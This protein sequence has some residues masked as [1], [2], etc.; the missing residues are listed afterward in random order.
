MDFLA[1]SSLPTS[2]SSMPY[3]H[4]IVKFP[5]LTW[6]LTLNSLPSIPYTHGL[7]TS[8]PS[9]GSLP[10]ALTAAS[11][12]VPAL[13]LRTL[14]CPH[15]VVKSDCGEAGKAST[16]VTESAASLWNEPSITRI[17]NVKGKIQRQ[18]RIRGSQKPWHT[19]VGAGTTSKSAHTHRSRTTMSAHAQPCRQRTTKSTH[20]ECKIFR[21]SPASIKIFCISPAS[22]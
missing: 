10:S 1:L 5:A 6:I 19:G 3:P 2:P 18:W 9:L 22:I 17:T 21:I 4:W 7:W 13:C 14:P 16:H 12:P 8:R 11:T 20:L 15:V